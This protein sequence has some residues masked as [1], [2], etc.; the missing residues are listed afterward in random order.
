MTHSVI[1]RPAEDE[2]LPY[3]S[4][5]IALVPDRDI[6]TTLSEQLDGTLALLRIVPES[7]G[8]FQYAPDKWTVKELV[9]HLTDG[10]GQPGQR[11]R[12]HG[13]HGA[14][15]HPLHVA[16]GADQLRRRAWQRDLRPWHR[17]HDPHTQPQLQHQL[18]QPAAE[19]TTG[20]H[21]VFGGRYCG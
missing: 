7:K 17:R 19:R 21:S 15:G 8:S 3:Y 12:Y 18:Q 6:V 9:G 14:H 11:D 2:Y 20:S 13:P 16:W 4:R 1:T 5:Y 10:D